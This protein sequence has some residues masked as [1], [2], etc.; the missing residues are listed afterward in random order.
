MTDRPLLISVLVAF[1]C[2]PCAD[3]ASPPTPVTTNAVRGPSLTAGR[4]P[5]D[6]APVTPRESFDCDYLGEAPPGDEPKLFAPGRVS[7]D[8]KN[9]HALAFSPD[10]TSLIF[11]RYPDR[12]SFRMARVQGGW[13][14][15]QETGFRGKEVSLDP[16]H[17]R[18]FYWDQG[19]LFFVRGCCQVRVDSSSAEGE[20]CAL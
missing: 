2:A 11:S 20:E 16:E 1:A 5:L 18:L 10:G 17:E 14:S 8:G 12:T 4:S 3:G 7:V 13:T 19:D 6:G 15:P 9:T